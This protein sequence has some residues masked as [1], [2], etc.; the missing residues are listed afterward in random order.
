MSFLNKD[1]VK[2]KAE[3]PKLQDT[4]IK[5]FLKKTPYWTIP[6]ETKIPHLIRQYEFSD[7]VSLLEF[8]NQ[9]GVESD[10]QDH[11]SKIVLEWSLVKIE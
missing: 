10:K 8:V 4:E 11:H 5:E 1:C 2:A 7:F 9:V 3:T 6:Y